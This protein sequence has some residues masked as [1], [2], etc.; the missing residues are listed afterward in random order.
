MH[1]VCGTGS[2]VLLKDALSK[3][4]G[5]INT[6]KANREFQEYIVAEVAIESDRDKIRRKE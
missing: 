6:L 4:T 3:G 2:G 1:R 5:G